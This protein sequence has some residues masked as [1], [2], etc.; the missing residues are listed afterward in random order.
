LYTLEQGKAS[1]HEYA[2][3][4][5]CLIVAIPNMDIVTG[6]CPRCQSVVQ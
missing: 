3:V 5:R 1:I 4:F 2:S 6:A